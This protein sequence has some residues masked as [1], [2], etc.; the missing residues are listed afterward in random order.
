MHGCN[1]L[2]AAPRP[3]NAK[4]QQAF[5]LLLVRRGYAKETTGDLWEFAVAIQYLRAIGLT[6]GDLPILSQFAG[7]SSYTLPNV[8]QHSATRLNRT[9]TRIIRVTHVS[10]SARLA[11]QPQLQGLSPS[12]SCGYRCPAP[13][14]YARGRS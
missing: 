14:R 6:T 8:H 10:L 9:A 13:R 3:L 5:A 1:T 12:T 7:T 4:L 11:F 2:D